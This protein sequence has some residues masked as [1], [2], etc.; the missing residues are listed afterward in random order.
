MNITKNKWT[1][2]DREQTSGHHCGEGSGE[3]Q[4]GR[5]RGTNYYA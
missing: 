4:D 3:G 5:L 1:H 2:R